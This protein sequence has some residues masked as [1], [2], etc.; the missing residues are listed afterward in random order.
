MCQ[1][2]QDLFYEI[3]N[4]RYD[5]QLNSYAHDFIDWVINSKGSNRPNK[6]KNPLGPVCIPV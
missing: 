5:L 1:G 6:V 3:S 4:Q 2:Q